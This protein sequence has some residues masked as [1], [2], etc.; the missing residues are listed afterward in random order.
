MEWIQGGPCTTSA[1]ILP[2]DRRLDD[3]NSSTSTR[4]S[5]EDHTKIDI[6]TALFLAG[7]ASGSPEL[8]AAVLPTEDDRTSITL[9]SYPDGKPSEAKTINIPAAPLNSSIA[10]IKTDL[11]NAAAHHSP[12]PVKSITSNLPINTK[13]ASNVEGVK[14]LESRGS[15]SFGNNTVANNGEELELQLKDDRIGTFAA[16]VPPH[17]SATVSRTATVLRFT[18]DSPITVILTGLNAKYGIASNE[19]LEY[20]ELTSNT[21]EYGFSSKA[22]DKTKLIINLAAPAKSSAVK[23]AQGAKK[24]Q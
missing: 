19:R 6:D 22:G 5:E 3:S 2:E 13:D 1:S 15:L 11:S 14:E 12:L 10:K 23:P 7:H 8:K 21:V 9:V 4:L 17:V 20:I 24:P 18:L 16:Q